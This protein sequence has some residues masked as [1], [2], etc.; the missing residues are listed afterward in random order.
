MM[1]RQRVVPI[2]LIAVFAIVCGSGVTPAHSAAVDPG[3]HRVLL[4][5]NWNPAVLSGITRRVD[6][7]P[8]TSVA[9][10]NH[11]GGRRGW[12]LVWSDPTR[13]RSVAL[14]D[15]W[16]GEI[17]ARLYRD[18][19]ERSAPRLSGIAIAT[20][21]PSFAGARAGET[22]AEWPNPA[23]AYV[24]GR[25]RALR[26]RVGETAKRLGLKVAS[27]HLPRLDGMLAPVVTLKVKDRARFEQGFNPACLPGWVFGTPR[28]RPA[29]GA[30]PAPYFGYFLSITDSSGRW[31]Q[32]TSF[33]PYEVETQLSS[34]AAMRLRLLKRGQGGL[35]ACPRRPS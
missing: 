19:R 2:G 6:P 4:T 3:T 25:G 27:F 14:G 9:W 32:S 30:G 15:V 13:N 23:L 35:G 20:R 29:G 26:D 11:P 28:T 34:R 22:T 1:A 24:Q 8:R 12:W 10:L 21:A 18:Q 5:R 7:H 33:V 17:V 16:T 31:L